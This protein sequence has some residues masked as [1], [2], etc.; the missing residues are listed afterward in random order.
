MQR[1]EFIILLGG[2]ALPRYR[3]RGSAV[4]QRAPQAAHIGFISGVDAAAAADFLAALRDGL[5][6]HG[7]VEPS[8]LKVEQLFANYNLDTIP[9]LLE[10]LERQRVNVIVTHAAA[11]LIVFAIDGDG[12]GG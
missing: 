10:Q 12:A 11:R 3:A 2:A 5:S 1:R 6:T 8:T 4:A 9:A 7:Y